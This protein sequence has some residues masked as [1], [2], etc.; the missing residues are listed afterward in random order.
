MTWLDWIAALASGY[1]S[2]VL[3]LRAVALKPKMGEYPEGPGDVRR[4]LF[5]LSLVMGA[6]ALT[7]AVGDYQASRTE[8]L[9]ASAVAYTAHVLWRNVRRQHLG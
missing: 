5:I 8:A 1:A 3:Q 9:I 7:V 4:A 2:A 6:Y